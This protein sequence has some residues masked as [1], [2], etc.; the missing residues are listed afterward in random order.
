M[1]E[2][3][4]LRYRVLFENVPIALYIT[5]PD[6]RIVDANPAL[7]RMLGYS[8]KQALLGIKATDLYLDPDDRVTQ[9]T[10]FVEEHIIENYET[11]LRRRDGKTIW[12]RDTCR[13]VRNDT[14][15]VLFYEGSLQDITE[16]RHAEE[17]LVYMARHDPL[18]GLFNR[19]TLRSI[20]DSEICRAQRYRHPIGVLMIDV[21]RFKEVNNRFGHAVGDMVLEAVADVL[22][23]SVRESDIVVR[24]G[25][26]EFLVLLTETDGE[27][28]IVRRRIQMQMEQLGPIGPLLDLPVTLAVGT[29]HWQPETGQSIEH[30]LSQ[31]DRAMY[32]E[33]RKTPS[34]QRDAP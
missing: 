3:P 24:Y 4:E 30:V 5:T 28:D 18:T 6:G 7:V 11:Q 32:A 14:G 20:L 23:R 16:E 19:Y 10:L 33:K 22:R 21:N 34:S 1:S 27:T 29:A 2:D 9:Q 25:G 12:V 31:A 8:D 26:D 13:A 17:E 15:D